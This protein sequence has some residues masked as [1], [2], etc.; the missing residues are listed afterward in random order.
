MALAQQA[1]SLTVAAYLAGEKDSPV[2]HEYI[3]GEVH[4]LAGASAAHNRIA[5]NICN[6]LDDHLADDDCEPFISDMKVMVSETVFYYPDVLVACDPP[7]AD[8]YYRR[9]PVLIVEV[10]SPSTAQTDRIEKL[11]AY[12][13]IKS[14]KEYVIVAQDRVQI[15]VFRR[16]RGERWQWELLTE[17]K[18]ELK[19]QSV[20]LT[21]PVEQVYR[22]VKLPKHPRRQSSFAEQKQ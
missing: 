12:K 5:R 14:L 21:L 2:K 3:D 6:R 20:G 4:A 15:E 13:Q 22:R 19:L 11:A 7:G 1:S 9:K 8:P 18:E 16:L 10:S 17:L